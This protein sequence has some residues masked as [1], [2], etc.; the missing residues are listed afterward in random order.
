MIFCAGTNVEFLHERSAGSTVRCTSLGSSSLSDSEYSPFHERS[1]KAGARA[2][3][4][5]HCPK[6]SVFAPQTLALRLLPGCKA[7]RQGGTGQPASS[8]RPQERR[9]LLMSTR[10]NPDCSAPGQHSRPLVGAPRVKR[11][12]WQPGLASSISDAVPTKQAILARPCEL[13]IQSQRRPYPVEI[14]QADVHSSR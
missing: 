2:N 3:N 8:L 11:S 12:R 14:G 4:A 1:C 6:T 7:H 9:S 10:R 13:P 5:A